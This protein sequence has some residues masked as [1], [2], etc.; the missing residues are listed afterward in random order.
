MTGAGEIGED[1]WDSFVS[2]DTPDGSSL[3]LVSIRM[4]EQR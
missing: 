1:A 4:S 2:L 3:M